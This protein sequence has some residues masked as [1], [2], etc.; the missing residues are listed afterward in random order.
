MKKI[1]ILLTSTL[2]LTACQSIDDF[3]QT[4]RELNPLGS[5]VIFTIPPDSQRL[6]AYKNIALNADANSLSLA[7]SIKGRIANAE[8]QNKPYFDQVLVNQGLI[9]SDVVLKVLLNNLSQNMTY[10]REDRVKCPGNKLVNTCKSSEGYH[11]TVQC[12]T[13]TVF[14]TGTLEGIHQEKLVIQ[15]FKSLTNEKTVCQDESSD[16]P[17]QQ[18]HANT[19]VHALSRA[20]I[21]A[22]IPS[23]DKRPSDLVEPNFDILPQIETLYEQAEDLLH[24]NEIAK[25][26]VIFEQLNTQYPQ[27]QALAFNLGYAYQAYGEFEKAAKLYA[28][29]SDPELLDDVQQYIVE[30]DKYIQN[31]F[32]SLSR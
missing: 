29:L 13:R 15:E 4:L 24:D 3:T 14:A 7:H 32:A 25:S 5:K 18:E 8:V 22:Y 12:K 11:Y 27:N 28:T 19:A 6:I 17:S 16:L 30:N 2:T 26:I 1:A 9:E 21:S 20:L 31:N 23:T 10:S